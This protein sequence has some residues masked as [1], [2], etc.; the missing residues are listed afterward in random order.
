MDKGEDIIKCA[1]RELKEETGFTIK[2][3]YEG[4]GPIGVFTTPYMATETSLVVAVEVDL[5]APENQTLTQKLDDNE[6][7]ENFIFE[8]IYE[9]NVLGRLDKILRDQK[10]SVHSTL[11]SFLMGFEL[12][13][14]LAQAQK[15]K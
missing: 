5:E 13:L 1:A 14:R 6:I 11:V 7:I 4:L 9:G 10:L 3:L 15:K 12:A 8:D 2:G